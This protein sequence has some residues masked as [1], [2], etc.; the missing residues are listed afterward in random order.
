MFAEVMQSAE[1][2]FREVME[3]PDDFELFM[4]DG[5]ATL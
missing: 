5:G 3:M 1:D 4:F 2:S